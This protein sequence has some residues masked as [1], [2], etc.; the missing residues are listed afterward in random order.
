[1][2][3]HAS[4]L[5]QTSFM[6]KRKGHLATWRHGALLGT[7][8]WIFYWPLVSRCRVSSPVSC[9]WM[10]WHILMKWYYVQY[11]I[12]WL[13]NCDWFHMNSQTRANLFILLYSVKKYS[14]L[15]FRETSTAP[16]QV[17]LHLSSP[18]P[19]SFQPPNPLLSLLPGKLP[20]SR[21]MGTFQL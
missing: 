15:A 18:S 20:L 5:H 11:K 16:N 12:F 13:Y 9:F 3:T 14:C 10:I 2:P 8:L 17:W 7:R 4:I 21:W 19:T 1:M 6:N